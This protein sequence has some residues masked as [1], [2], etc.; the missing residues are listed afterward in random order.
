MWG[1][2]GRWGD[3]S[4][5]KSGRVTAG[6]ADSR[7][8]FQLAAEGAARLGEGKL[9]GCGEGAARLGEGGEGEGA[10]RLGEGASRLGEGEG[11]ARGAATG[12]LRQ[13]LG[14]KPFMAG[15]GGTIDCS[16]EGT[17]EGDGGAAG[18]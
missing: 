15:G 7:S 14:S 6:G 4:H 13:I 12:L 16:Q 3:R 11:A 8:G 18:S 17:S 10:A 9:L 1:G 2:G 5:A